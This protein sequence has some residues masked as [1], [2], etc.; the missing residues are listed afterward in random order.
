MIKNVLKIILIGILPALLQAGCAHKGGPS[1]DMCP[2]IAAFAN[3]IAD[4]QEHSVQLK[5]DWGGMYHK[6][7][8]L[9]FA[10]ECEH[11]GFAP[12][13]E[14]CAYLLENTST[15]FAASNY[16]RAL[17]C[18]GVKAQDLSPADDDRLPGSAKARKLFGLRPDKSVKLAFDHATDSEPPRLTISARRR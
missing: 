3:A 15:E 18:V 9:M 11:G 1:D 12:G 5:T 7:E 8:E 6:S 16:R 2:A 13:K 14:L 4:D 10:K 17:E